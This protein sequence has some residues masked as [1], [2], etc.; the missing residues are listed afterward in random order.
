ML[1]FTRDEYNSCSDTGNLCVCVALGTKPWGLAHISSILLFSYLAVS[2]V[3]SD[4][5]LVKI[6]ILT[7]N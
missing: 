7:E 6:V 4:K 2:P 3:N 5:L 1:I